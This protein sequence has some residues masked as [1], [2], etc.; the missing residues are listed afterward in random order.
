MVAPKPERRGERKRAAPADVRGQVL[1]S[2]MR[3]FAAH[4]FDG[5]SLQAIADEVGVAKPSVLHY[6]PSKEALRTSVLDALLGHWSEAL[7]RLLLAATAGEGRFD[8]LVG[9]MSPLKRRPDAPIH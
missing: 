2:A 7:P 4:G 9:E 5:T 3:L 6:F 1:A 8:A